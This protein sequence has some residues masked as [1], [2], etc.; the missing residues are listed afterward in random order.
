MKR[1][2]INHSFLAGFNVQEIIKQSGKF[3]LNHQFVFQ[4][5]ENIS[6]HGTNKKAKV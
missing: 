4:T 5:T 2:K 6:S 3:G 1:P